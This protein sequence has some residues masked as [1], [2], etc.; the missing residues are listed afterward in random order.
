MQ[1]ALRF[2]VVEFTLLWALGLVAASLVVSALA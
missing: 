1:D 2:S